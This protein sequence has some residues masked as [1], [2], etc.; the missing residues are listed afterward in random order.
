RVYRTNGGSGSVVAESDDEV[1]DKIDR[2]DY[3]VDHYARVL[4]DNFASRLARAFTPGDFATLFA[5]PDQFSLFTPSIA[6]I[7]PV[8]H[9]HASM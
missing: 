6:S 7:R 8:L 9:A 4:L 1:H 2:R 5:D 3:D